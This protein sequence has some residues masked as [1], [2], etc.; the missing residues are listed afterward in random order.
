[1]SRSSDNL[2]I[3]YNGD[4]EEHVNQ[5]QEQLHRKKLK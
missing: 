3:A 2:Y 5:G 4:L 1:M